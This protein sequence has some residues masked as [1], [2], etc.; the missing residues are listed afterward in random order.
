FRSRQAYDSADTG[1]G[2][3][4]VTATATSCA[5]SS[6]VTPSIQNIGR[7]TPYTPTRNTG[8]R[9]KWEAAARAMAVGGV[10][11]RD[12]NTMPAPKPAVAQP[13]SRPPPTPHPAAGVIPTQ[14]PSAATKATCAS[15]SSEP[16][17]NLHHHS[18]IRPEG[19]ASRNV[20]VP[21]SLS[22]ASSIEPH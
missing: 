5:C 21:P 16:A 13:S 22:P 19:S 20:C 18:G 4:P 7:A 9:L 6:E 1:S 15:T 10:G 11:A 14:V 17:K 2:N 3:T 8:A 12:E